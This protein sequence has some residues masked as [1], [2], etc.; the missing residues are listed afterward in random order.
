MIVFF[1]VFFKTTI[2]QKYLI[3]K[4]PELDKE[5]TDYWIHY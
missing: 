1:N 2:Y 5:F 4:N 3:Y